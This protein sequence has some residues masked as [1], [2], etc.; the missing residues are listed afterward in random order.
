MRRFFM[1]RHIDQSGISGT[2][3]VLEG[4]VTSSGKCFVE[5]RPP[6]TSDCIYPS[7]EMFK[8]IHLDGHPGCSEIIW[9]DPE[10]HEVIAV[11]DI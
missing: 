1:H 9:M 5:W 10:E 2:G 7:F 11:I 3:K 6:V 8:K 4:V